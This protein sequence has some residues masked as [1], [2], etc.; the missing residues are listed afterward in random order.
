MLNVRPRI[1]PCLTMI[2]RGLY[3]TTI[4]A[5]PRYLGDPV[6]TLRLFN[7]KE[8]DEI[9]ILSIR[10]STENKEPDLVFLKEI[11]SEA[12]MPLSYGG[13]V[14]SLKQMEKLFCIGFE[15]IIANTAFNENPELVR[16]AVKEFGSQSLVVSIDVRSDLFNRKSCWI[17]GGSVKL[18]NSPIDYAK[19]AEELGAG[20]LLLQSI[21]RDGT[22]K[23]YDI[24]LIK[25][26]SD[27]VSIPV[28]ACGGAKDINDVKQVLTDGH[29]DAA[30]ASSM[31][32]YY[33]KQKAVLVS[34]PSEEE[35]I[36]EFGS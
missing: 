21:D 33:G 7:N 10:N 23:G 2:N 34:Y 35:L 25:N 17:K 16:E 6:N 20:E 29:A 30:A 24:D 26:I 3:K 4:F 14:K 11:A 8:V 15:K 19:K 18:K 36:K 12:F 27:A 9:C 28:I 1:I 31:F 32:V 5:K 13:G 22:M